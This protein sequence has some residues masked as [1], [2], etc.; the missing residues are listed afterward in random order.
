MSRKEKSVFDPLRFFTKLNRSVRKRVLHHKFGEEWNTQG[1][2]QSRKYE[3]YKAYLKHQKA[4]LATHDFK[5]YDIE[6]R[7]AL[8]ERLLAL[9]IDWRGLSVLCRASRTGSAVTAFLDLGC[10]EIG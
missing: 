6:F 8:R 7:T 9:D 1:A 4:K 2:F 10:G 5:K 3:S